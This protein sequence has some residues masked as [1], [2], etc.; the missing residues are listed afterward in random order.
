VSHAP[1]EAA[2]LADYL[3]LMAGGKALASGPLQEMLTRLDLAAA[4]GE[5]VGAAL[6]ATVIAQEADGLTRLAFSGGE[7]LVSASHHPVGDAV[8]C[9][10][11]AADVSLA[12]SPAQD[13]SILNVLPATVEALAELATPGHVLVRLV[14]AGDPAWR[15][16]ARITQRS[17]AALG[18]EPGLAVFA[19]IKAVA[20][21]G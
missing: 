5:E 12:L 10:V 18:L 11:R 13:S 8:H 4:F 7:L 6:E 1:D 9:R 16:L 2:R 17:A 21:L 19:Q 20:L 3:V 14:L 15:L